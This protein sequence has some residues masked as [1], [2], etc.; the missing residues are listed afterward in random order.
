MIFALDVACNLCTKNSRK[1]N[2]CKS[3]FKS[4]ATIE[5]SKLLFLKSFLI[6]GYAEMKW[7]NYTLKARRRIRRRVNSEKDLWY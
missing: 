3:N 7:N 2:F 5:K 6:Q 4:I 1:E